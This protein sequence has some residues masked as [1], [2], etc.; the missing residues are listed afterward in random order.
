MKKQIGLMVDSL[1]VSN[2]LWELL[3]LSKTAE[4]Y[5]I[6][7]LLVNQKARTK[8]YFRKS[9]DLLVRHGLSRFLSKSL[10][11]ILHKFEFF[12]NK[13]IRNYNNFYTKHTLNE[14]EF[15][16]VRLSPRISKSNLVY[17]YDER[18]IDKVS[19][20]N[21]DLIIRGGGGILRGEILDVCPNGIISFHHGDN[22]IN[23]GGPPGFWEVYHENPRT[24]F[25][26]Q[27]LKDELDGGDVLY[28]GYL[29]TAW[30]YSLNL[31]RLYEI[32]NPF[33]HKVLEDLTSAEPRLPV[34]EKYPYSYPLYTQPNVFQISKYL[35]KTFAI[36]I[37]KI[38]RK[39]RRK[40]HRWGI[41]YQFINN[42]SEV[43]LWR[44][45]KI[46][47][48]ENR[49]L[50]DPFVIKYK[51]DYYCFVEDF[52]YRT[53]RGSISAYKITTDGYD[54]IG[55]VLS[56]DFHLSY[57]FM[58]EYENQIFM[59]PETHEKNE[60]RL[61]RCIEFPAKWEFHKTIMRDVSAADT[62]IF[63]Y[64]GKWWLFTNFDDS[65]VGD[66]SSQL[67]IFSSESPLSD[68]WLAHECN[69]VIFDPLTARNGGL[70]HSDG[71]IFRVFQRQGFDMY[72]EAC[73]VAKITNLSSDRYEEE[74]CAIFEPKF[75]K[76]ISGTHTFNC[77]ENLAVIDYV[78]VSRT[79]D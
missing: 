66:H 7:T 21:L 22:N 63:W 23:R 69:P 4:N 45:Y 20:L 37:K 67:H 9:I 24:G 59:C 33:L 40:N 14:K 60:I 27:R 54:P 73:G 79:K 56:E 53:K 1:D 29:T 36:L 52:D 15:T 38:Y 51:T 30:L 18:D 75:F 71:E 48:P 16:V 46:K 42:W 78:K 47:N 64:N 70:F 2:Q 43:A 35:L 12:I 39:L 55:I 13:R 44:S 65:I 5:E 76:D 74:T 61:Y 49:F 8:N 57:P 26:I 17:R 10:F 72:G 6:T 31:V 11:I 19:S 68:K 58:F 62:N 50:A 28:R 32:A 77:V 34:Q 25:I 41:A 3:E